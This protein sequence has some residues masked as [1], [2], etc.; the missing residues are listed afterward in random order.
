MSKCNKVKQALKIE[1]ALSI[2]SLAGLKAKLRDG[3]EQNKK[4]ILFLNVFVYRTDMKIT[5]LLTSLNVEL[6][7]Y[8]RAFLL[9]T[10]WFPN[11]PTHSE[12]VYVNTSIPVKIGFL[13]DPG[14]VSAHV[15]IISRF[16]K[17]E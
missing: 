13:E 9:K 1:K 5:L 16:Q 12:R 11:I 4:E 3:K 7:I 15:N 2:L 10:E 6:E 17:P 14:Y 8:S